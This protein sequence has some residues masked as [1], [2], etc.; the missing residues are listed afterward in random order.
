MMRRYRRHFS[1]SVLQAFHAISRAGLSFI[2]LGAFGLAR[3]AI[4]YF[5]ARASISLRVAGWC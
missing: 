4:V 3:E 5:R 2:S 1:A